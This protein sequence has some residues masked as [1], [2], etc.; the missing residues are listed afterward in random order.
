MIGRVDRRALRTSLPGPAPT[1]DVESP[2]KIL[3]VS[4]RANAVEHEPRN[5]STTSTDEET[6][7]PPEGVIDPS[8][9]GR[10]PV[11][12]RG[13]ALWGVDC[14]LDQRHN[15]GQ[16]VITKQMFHR[17]DLVSPQR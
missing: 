16:Q 12:E 17:H 8:S 4:L 14:L 1:T 11:Y 10:R 7:G 2:R 15:G 5:V 3:I 6:E 13:C 9:R